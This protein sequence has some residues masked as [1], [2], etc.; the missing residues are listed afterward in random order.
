LV[1]DFSKKNYNNTVLASQFDTLSRYV[2][3]TL[4]DNSVPV[5][6][7]NH[8]V[9]IYAKKPDGTR[10]F[11]DA[12]I[13]DAT[14]GKVRVELTNQILAVTGLVECELTLYGTDGSIIASQ[15]FYINVEKTLRDDSA[16]E[17]TNEF[18]ALT[19]LIA[20][21]QQI[22]NEEAERITAENIRN[23]NENTRKSNE[24]TR[25]SN[26]TERQN[27]EAKR[28][29]AESNRA[30]AETSR[31]SA[32]NSRISN[33]T[34]RQNN[35]II[36]Q[37]TLTIMRDRLEQ[38]NNLDVVKTEDKVN[39]LLD[40][41]KIMVK[42]NN[43][44]TVSRNSVVINPLESYNYTSSNTI[45]SDTVITIN[46]MDTKEVNLLSDLQIT[47]LDLFKA[48]PLNKVCYKVNSEG[49]LSLAIL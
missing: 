46:N 31:V 14:N 21:N 5:D 2:D 29:S 44:I 18:T 49:L 13:I 20:E 23:S 47:N 7:T 8:T 10:V 42:D 39:N 38:F 33:E 48:T 22:K 12:E 28:I 34:E 41:Q 35:E 37:N 36:R 24:N 6:I 1:L 3:I 17:S 19:K 26:E 32:E 25:K 9:R 15:K 40:K 27:N 11:N 30:A 45:P 43:G 16:I 4:I